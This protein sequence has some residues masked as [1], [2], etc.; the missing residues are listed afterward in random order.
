[1]AVLFGSFPSWYL[2]LRRVSAGQAQLVFY[3]SRLTLAS[4]IS[5]EDSTISSSSFSW[6]NA[7]EPWRHVAVTVTQNV[8]FRHNIFFYVD[9]TFIS[10]G[11]RSV[12]AMDILEAPY[13]IPEHRDV[14]HVG[15]VNMKRFPEVL[16]SGRPYYDL[17]MYTAQ[18]DEVR[19]H[20]EA[21]DTLT[22]GFQIT[23]LRRLA[24]CNTPYEQRDGS[25]C[26]ARPRLTPPNTTLEQ[27][28]CR[29]GY[30]Q[31]HQMPGICM[32]E[33]TGNLLRQEDCSCD[34]APS[35]FQ[36]WLIS[37]V[38]L[39]GSGDVK[40]AT[41]YDADHHIL[42]QLGYVTLPRRIALAE[43]AQV[44]VVEVW[45][46]ASA[47]SVSL[48]VETPAPESLRLA[49]P[50]LRSVLLQ[51]DRPALL[52]HRLALDYD[53]PTLSCARCPGEAPRSVLPRSDTM[54][55]RCA[56]GYGANLLGK[57]VPAGGPLQAPVISLANGTYH[58][59]GTRV[60]MSFPPQ[61]VEGPWLLAIRYEYGSLP[62]AP[63]CDTSP[64]YEELQGDVPG[65][66]IIRRQES[67]KLRAV[68]CHPLHQISLESVVELHGNDHMNPPRCVASGNLST[69]TTYALQVQVELLVDQ[70][71]DASIFY[72]LEGSSSPVTYTAP[73][74]LTTPGLV[75]ISSWAEKPGFDPSSRTSCSYWIDGAARLTLR[76]TWPE[77]SPLL[78][79]SSTEG[80]FLVERDLET[81]AFLLEVPGVTDTSSLQ[82]QYR[83]WRGLLGVGSWQ[84]VPSGGAMHLKLS[85]HLEAANTTT[86]LQVDW[87]LKEPGYVWT[88][89]GYVRVLIIKTRTEVPSIHAEP[90]VLWQLGDHWFEGPKRDVAM[91]QT[92]TV[93]LLQPNPAARVLFSIR[94]EVGQPEVGDGALLTMSHENFTSLTSA[95]AM[96][97]HFRSSVPNAGLQPE[98]MPNAC[99]GTAL[100]LLAVEVP[101]LCDYLGPFE[102]LGGAVVTA[103]AIVAGQLESPAATLLVPKELEPSV[104]D[105]T[106]RAF[107]EVSGNVLTITPQLQVLPSV[108]SFL[109]FSVGQPDAERQSCVLATPYSYLSTINSS[110][111]IKDCSWLPY[112]GPRKLYLETLLQEAPAAALTLNVTILTTVRR[113]GYLWSFPLASTVLW[114]RERTPLPKVVQ[115]LEP[116]AVMPKAMVW[117]QEGQAAECFFTL[118][119]EP[120]ELS[121]VPSP[122]LVEVP[123]VT[124][125]VAS[126]EE[127]FRPTAYRTALHGP[128]MWSSDVELCAWPHACE[129]PMNG[130]LPVQLITV[131]AGYTRLCAWA[132]WQGYLESTPACELMGA[133]GTTAVAEPSFVPSQADLES[134]QDETVILPEEAGT[135]VTLR[136]QLLRPRSTSSDASGSALPIDSRR[137][138]T[139]TSMPLFLPRTHPLQYR[140]A[141]AAMDVKLLMQPGITQNSLTAT[142]QFSAWT[143][144]GLAA[145]TPLL[146][147]PRRSS[148]DHVFFVVDVRLLTGVNR[149]SAETRS[150]ALLLIGTESSPSVVHVGRSLLVDTAAGGGNSTLYFKWL[151]GTITSSFG[152]DLLQAQSE[153]TH[154][155]EAFQVHPAATLHDA[156]DTSRCLVSD[157]NDLVSQKQ[158][159]TSLG[160][161]TLDI[162]TSQRWSLW[163]T[164]GSD[165]LAAADARL[166]TVERPCAAPQDVAYARTI[167]CMEGSLIE[168]GTACSTICQEGYSPTVAQ[169][170]CSQGQLS[171]PQFACAEDSCSA[172][173]NVNY[174]ASSACLEGN[175]VAPGGVCTAQCEAG[176]APS[177][178]SLGCSR[179]RLTP[180]SFSCQEAS[181]QAPEVLHAASP[182][183]SGLP[184]IKSRET[185]T[186][187]CQDGYVASQ[188]LLHCTRGQLNP[189]TF[190]CEPGVTVDPSIIIASVPSTLLA[191][192]LALMAAY[193]FRGP[194]K[195]EEK[196]ASDPLK[197]WWQCV[198]EVEPGL[199]VFCGKEPEELE[200]R[201][202]DHGPPTLF[203][204]CS[205]CAA[206]LGFELEEEEDQQEEQEEELQVQVDEGGSNGQPDEA[207]ASAAASA[208]SASGGSEGNMRLSRPPTFTD[209]RS[210]KGSISDA[211]RGLELEKFL[212]RD[213][214][215]SQAPS[216]I[217]PPAPPPDIAMPSRRPDVAASASTTPWPERRRLD[218]PAEG[219]RSSERSSFPPSS[220]LHIRTTGGEGGPHEPFRNE[221]SRR[222]R[223]SLADWQDSPDERPRSSRPEWEGE[224][225]GGRPSGT[226]QGRRARG[227][228]ESR[229]D[230]PEMERPEPRGDRNDERDVRRRLSKQE[231]RS[232]ATEDGS[233]RSSRRTSEVRQF[234]GSPTGPQEMRR[235]RRPVV[236]AKGVGARRVEELGATGLRRSLD[237]F[238]QVI[239]RG[240]LMS[241][242]LT[243]P[244]EWRLV[245][246]GV[247]PHGLDSDEDEMLRLTQLGLLR[248]AVRDGIR[249][250]IWPLGDEGEK[251]T[252]CSVDVRKEPAGIC[253]QQMGRAYLTSLARLF[254]CGRAGGAARGGASGASP[255]TSSEAPELPVEEVVEGHTAD[256]AE[257]SDAEAVL[258]ERD[259]GAD[260]HPPSSIGMSEEQDHNEHELYPSH[261][262]AVDTGGSNGDP[263]DALLGDGEAASSHRQKGKGKGASHGGSSRSS[264]IEGS[265]RGRPDNGR[266]IDGHGS[267][268]HVRAVSAEV[269]LDLSHDYCKQL[270]DGMLYH[271]A[272]F[273]RRYQL[274]GRV[275]NLQLELLTF[276]P[277][278]IWNLEQ[279][280]EDIQVELARLSSLR[281]ELTEQIPLPQALVPRLMGPEGAHMNVLSRDLGVQITL[282]HGAEP[283]VGAEEQ[284]ATAWMVGAPEVLLDARN[285]LENHL[286]SLSTRSP[287]DLEEQLAHERQQSVHIFVDNSNICIGCQLLPTGIRDFQQR[288]YIKGFTGALQGVRTVQRRVVMGSRP[289]APSIWAA[290]KRAGYEVQTAHRDPR[291]REEFVDG[292]LVGEALMHVLR[293]PRCDD[294]HVLILATGDGN[295]GGQAPN[296]AGANFQ[297]LVQTVAEGRVP[298]WSVEVWCW[299]SSCHGVYKRMA[300]EGQIRLCFLDGLRKQVTMTARSTAE[301]VADP[302]AP[303]DTCVQCLQ[304]EPTHAFYPCTHRVLCALC[305]AETRP[306]LNTHPL[307]LCFICRCPWQDI[308]VAEQRMTI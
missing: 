298:G 143:D 47:T 105:L 264:G 287:A 99:G 66:D 186:P 163:V 257:A 65:L 213:E 251:W 217:L 192:S 109:S 113:P 182:A 115:I 5:A 211:V 70:Q 158:F 215:A 225:L 262:Q 151:Q 269:S 240:L 188:T 276:L 59:A 14:F 4:H 12:A 228:R 7:R 172:P 129:L 144:L 138:S 214:D 227:E 243:A 103:Y 252:A 43:A 272:F 10:S 141:V 259:P 33:C 81:L 71:P 155:S 296:T 161:L 273:L 85:D 152:A 38:H 56:S 239:G 40:N 140:Y 221:R 77:P 64:K 3:H 125:S 50:E 132:L 235:S 223:M 94:S 26:H 31:C 21:L 280:H 255:A 248:D 130:T 260:D 301:L 136:A 167:S 76:A 28:Q 101:K 208:A 154:L 22:L 48:E 190:V 267:E 229:R 303:E 157:S 135:D 174:S 87:R 216:D 24:A 171:P 17:A 187:L 42:G 63:N 121:D 169:L 279:L 27:T 178:Q 148:S 202:E 293:F 58:T 46:G 68:L 97:E 78:G 266:S 139:A 86:L 292:R 278:G 181:C 295:L 137:L 230:T 305:A 268:E 84:A 111:F 114:L 210:S 168:S 119:Y 147:L 79:F 82:L 61:D 249:G 234:P 45:G 153:V 124:A 207:S 253:S 206:I 244:L 285:A 92:H 173:P 127:A 146:Q 166:V 1:M 247:P 149:W 159:C 2:A 283:G 238:V 226:L 55:C 96:L 220:A 290:W 201:Y 306:H 44:A 73:F 117:L 34:C 288:I 145:P 160:P 198:K 74:V 29:A 297:N 277:E 106:F 36:T 275:S 177:V 179:G 41:V 23:E 120:L 170:Q 218:S 245:H 300:K 224:T 25:A 308:R 291:N 123:A 37:A 302:L 39:T 11:Y 191:G 52:H 282:E 263:D 108:S 16:S 205:S 199:C 203:R 254:R 32:E 196:E 250:S 83:L 200:T 175:D 107:P 241:R 133:S 80:A 150:A 19:V 89:P 62:D 286:I 112:N 271:L 195:I 131:P 75:T 231:R 281:V 126:I 30:E 93:Q 270:K 299:R 162:P 15:P 284:T 13:I 185:C 20:Q 9:G 156:S 246:N 197:E 51:A 8:A 69:E 232:K 194:A 6:D 54:S 57:C 60:R 289:S 237:G 104:E 122:F 98:E 35:Y 91:R 304:A 261:H 180:S 258:P 189:E 110:K 294:D 88:N 256:V 222:E 100:Q 193:C 219:D 49:V 53:D 165:G 67:V 134:F 102:V 233:F 184:Q 95:G 116:G 164:A 307:G 18:L 128:D 183:C 242:G 274:V 265:T 176:Y 209:L 204:S 72:E 90:L 212:T 142:L 236:G 118:H